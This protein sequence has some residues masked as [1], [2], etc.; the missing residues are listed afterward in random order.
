[1]WK[2]AALWVV[3]T[4]RDGML[5]RWRN[6][7]QWL[8]LAFALWAVL[9]ALTSV[10]VHLSV[11]GAH[12]SYDG[13]YSALAF[14]MIAFSAAEAFDPGDVPAAI[15]TLAFGAGSVAAWYGIVQLHDLETKGKHW[16]FVHWIKGLPFHNVFSTLGN[17]NHLAGYIAIVLPTCVLVGLR[18]RRRTV[19]VGVGLL[20]AVLLAELLQT[21]ARGAW[22]ATIAAAVV[23]AVALW[24]EIRRRPL[25]P[26]LGVSAAVLGAAAIFLGGGAHYVGG[27]ISTLF[28]SNGR[29][30]VGQRFDMWAASFHIGLNHPLTGTGPDTFV[31]VFPRYENASWVRNLGFSYAADGAHDIFMNV[32]ADRGFVG[33]AILVALVVFVGIRGIGALRRLRAL[34]RSGTSAA[35]GA[36]AQRML[37]AAV[38][39]GLVAYVVQAIF[40]VQQIALSFSWWF[41]LGLFCVV[42]AGAGVPDSFSPKRLLGIGLAPGASPGAGGSAVLSGDGSE[43]MGIDPARAVPDG[44]SGQAGQA[45]GRSGQAGQ[46][47]QVGRAGNR[48]RNPNR[49]PNRAGISWPVAVAGVSSAL[50]AALLAYGADGPWRA[51]HAYWA[52]SGEQAAYVRAQHQGAPAT[53]TNR[54]GAAYFADIRHAMALNPWAARYPAAAGVDLAIAATKATKSTLQKTDLTQAKT[55]LLAAVR[56]EPQASQYRYEIAQVFAG[57]AHLYPSQAKGYYARAV[58]EQKAA[59]HWEPRDPAFSK[60]LAKLEKDLK[61]AG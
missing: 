42:S 58:S 1:M 14:T 57:L 54:L 59:V 4:V 52:A 39:A 61:S 19:Q 34:E 2:L 18:G 47:G 44:R 29:S 21:A 37:L 40:N 3:G 56:A 5:P 17:P 43:H 23:L 33:L 15:G 8:V 36:T 55:Y 50:V 38:T 28:S 20:V 27:K 6:G 60:Y 46:A 16:D 9:S 25:V 13:L 7:M 30:S 22:V 49:R 32:L 26:A 41:L 31:Y 45:A 10:N 12:G 24:P 51:G 11:L 53:T 48:R 35:S